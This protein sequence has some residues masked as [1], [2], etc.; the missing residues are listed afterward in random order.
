MKLI[1]AMSFGVPSVVSELT[2][3]QLDLTDGTEVLVAKS[4]EE[5]VQKVI[6]LYRNEKLWYKIQQRNAIEYV[7]VGKGATNERM[8]IKYWDDR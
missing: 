5:F 4:T 7:R 8:L 2:A 1:E 3:S 6:K